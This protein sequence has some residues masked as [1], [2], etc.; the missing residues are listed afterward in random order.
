MVA[1]SSYNHL[2]LQAA[3]PGALAIRRGMV[4]ALTPTV[5]LPAHGKSPCFSKQT[6][7]I[8]CYQKHSETCCFMRCLF[9]VISNNYLGS[10]SFRVHWV[11][12]VHHLFKGIVLHAGMWSWKDLSFCNRNLLWKQVSWKERK[13]AAHQG[14]RQDYPTLSA[15]YSQGKSWAGTKPASGGGRDRQSALTSSLIQSCCLKPHLKDALGHRPHC[16]ES[17]N[18]RVLWVGRDPQRSPSPTVAATTM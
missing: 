12:P 18:H 1:A 7:A 17:Q 8:R 9:P 3:I 5:P 10:F 13:W 14:L 4:L 16:C 11:V 6:V 15:S 2:F